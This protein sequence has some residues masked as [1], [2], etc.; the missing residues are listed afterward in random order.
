[1]IHFNIIHLQEV[2]STNAYLKE[3]SKK[4][5]VEEGTA[6]MADFQTA[7]KGRG[8]NSWFAGSGLN[9]LMS[10][11]LRPSLKSSNHFMLNEMI[12]LAVKDVLH[13]YNM[14]A[15]IKWPNDIF[16]SNRKIAGILIENVLIG[17]EIV[18]SVIGLGLNVNQQRFPVELTNPV[19]MA[20]VLDR[21]IALPEL[22]KRVFDFI[23]V[24][25]ESL[26]KGE[27]GLMHSEY[28]SHLY[29]KGEKVYFTSGGEKKEG[30]LFNIFQ[31]GE[32]II[33]HSN[34]TL[35]SYLFDD[36]QDLT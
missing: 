13:S 19:S 34:G 30:M 23:G 33:M 15:N 8:N 2:N 27:F 14:H 35:Q 36:A 29:K 21:S 3:L 20:Q 11:L 24:R 28:V 12:S 9:V 18:E 10:V 26:K 32:L 22:K 31:G 7:G 6:I 17:D 4:E 16:V 5:P 1:M 25:Y